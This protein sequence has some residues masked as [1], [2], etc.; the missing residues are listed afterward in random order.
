LKKTLSNVFHLLLHSKRGSTLEQ[1]IWLFKL[2]VLRG[3][4]KLAGKKRKIQGMWRA[5]VGMLKCRASFGAGLHLKTSP[6][7]LP[8]FL[9]TFLPSFFLPSFFPSSLSP[10]LPSSLPPFLST[11]LPS[12]FLPSFLISFFL[13]LFL[14]PCRHY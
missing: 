5:K 11:F 9:P 4:L 10:S 13:P 8:S 2:K 3:G 6:P 1:I 7:F 12:S 14:L